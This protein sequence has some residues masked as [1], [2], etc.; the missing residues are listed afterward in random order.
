MIKTQK[1]VPN[2]YYKESRD[3]Q[4]LGR[5]MDILF[6]SVYNNTKIISKNINNIENKGFLLELLCTSLGF[7]LKQ[8]YNNEQLNGLSSIF[9]ELLKNKGNI[10]SIKLL[11][12]LLLHIEGIDEQVKIEID[13]EGVLNIFIPSDILDLNLFYDVLDYIIPAGVIY[14]VRQS[15]VI[16]ANMSDQYVYNDSIKSTIIPDKDLVDKSADII[17]PQHPEKLAFFDPDSNENSN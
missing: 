17:H 2:V 8:E 14:N 7:K 1:L 15:I 12:N 10:N 3:F 13:E 9:L 11:V 5:I 6:N 16:K 4:L